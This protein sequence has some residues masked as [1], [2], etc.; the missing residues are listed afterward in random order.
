MDNAS[1]LQSVGTNFDRASG[2]L[3]LSDDLAKKI[4]TAYSTYIVRFG[5]RP[6]GGVH[7]FTGYRTAHSE[8]FAR[9][10]GGIR[11]GPYCRS[12]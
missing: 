6:R 8:Y 7:T 3:G 2:L 10:K 9:V 11:Y 4:K 1:F 5:V 12:E